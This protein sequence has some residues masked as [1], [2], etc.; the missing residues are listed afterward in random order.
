MKKLICLFIIS[1]SIAFSQNKTHYLEGTIGKSK[2]YLTI[3]EDENRL[4]VNYFY[5]NS[6]KDIMLEGTKTKNSYNFNFGER[7]EE[8]ISEEFSLVKNKNTFVG[9]W[10]N[11]NGKKLKVS[12]APINFNLYKNSENSI[13]LENK[14]DLVKL[15]FLKFSQDS[16]STYNNKKILWFSEKHCSST[17]FRLSDDFSEKTRQVINPIL[18]EIHITQTLSQLN[19]TSL[20]YYNS[21]ND[22]ENTTTISFLNSNL[23]GFQ[24][25]SSWYCGGA[26][27]DF[28]GNGYLIDLNNG[29][30]YEIDEII[31]FDK[32]VTTE[33]KSGFEAYSK[34]RNDFFAPK[35]FELINNNE[36]F[37]K[38]ENDYD[39]C[40][41]TDIDVWDFVS[42]N[43]TEK[44]IEFTPY[45]ARVERSC[46]EPFLVEFKDLE[47]YKNIQF[48][49][50]FN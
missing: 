25:F 17:F 2:I 50:S 33:E 42:W 16:V 3:D 26:H 22:I 23:L 44:G 4:F 27:P 43:Y 32:S 31:A 49:Y 48:P 10:K 35:L 1:T 47:K 28:G 13:T 8:S 12:L 38:P 40:D 39:V 29:K 14:M 7:T 37:V 5:Q 15:K 41:Y 45:F 36:H 6:L 30:Q 46:E 11:K 21:G 19:C 20:F 9:T 24:I 18:N 34:Y